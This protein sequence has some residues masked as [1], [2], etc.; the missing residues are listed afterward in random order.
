MAR[1]AAGSRPDLT[2]RVRRVS[3]PREST[4]YGPTALLTP[5]FSSTTDAGEFRSRTLAASRLADLRPHPPLCLVRVEE[6]A[7]LSGPTFGQRLVHPADA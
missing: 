7:D 5:C 3:F 2:G 4:A 6:Y 1:R